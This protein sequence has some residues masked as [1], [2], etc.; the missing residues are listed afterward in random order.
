MIDLDPKHV[1]QWDPRNGSTIDSRFGSWDRQLEK[2]LP[3]CR[4]AFGERER[5]RVPIGRMMWDKVFCAQC[6]ELYGACTPNIAHVFF[7]CDTCV[8]VNGPP[9]DCVE[10]R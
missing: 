4:V 1:D 5:Q 2:G 6:H 10:V 8:R 7:I 3:D 9:A